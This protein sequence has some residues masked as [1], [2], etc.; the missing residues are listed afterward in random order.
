MTAGLVMKKIDSK[1]MNSGEAT[2][3][4]AGIIEGLAQARFV[5][6]AKNPAGRACIYGWFYDDSEAALRKIHA[7][8]DRYPDAMPG[9][10]IGTLVAVK[11]GA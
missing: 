6:D 4:F 2:F 8:F 3:F 7:A 9:Q 11:C 1:E 5:R 10:V